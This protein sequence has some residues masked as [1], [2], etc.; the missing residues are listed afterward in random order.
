MMDAQM[1]E[2]LQMAGLTAGDIAWF[3]SFGCE[4]TRVPSPGPDEIGAFRRREAA[5]NASVAALSYA[6]RGASPE[7][8]LAAA[9]GAQVANAQ[10]KGQEDE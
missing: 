2:R 5:L 8:K 10:D 1:R 9:I 6:E 4:D 7:G 3:D